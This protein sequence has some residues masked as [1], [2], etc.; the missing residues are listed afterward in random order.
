V[1]V[2]PV[3]SEVLAGGPAP[4]PLAQE[5]AN[6]VT[7]WM[8]NGSSRLGNDATGKIEEPGAT[9]MDAIWTPIAQAVLSPVLGELTNEFASL[10]GPESTP[11]FQSGWYGY[12][13]KDL[14]SELGQPVKGAFSRRY[15]GNG[16]LAACRA[17]LWAAIQTAAEKLAAAQGPEPAAWRESAKRIG[18]LP[19]LIQYTMRWTNRS[20]FQQV[21]EFD[22]HAPEECT[23][24]W[25]N[26]AGGSWFTPGNWSKGAPP[27]PED[28]ACIT[29]NGTYTVTMTQTGATG[30][31]EVNSLTL[32]GA[33]GTQTL[34]VGSSC[35]QSAALTAIAAI[36]NGAHGAL[37]LTNGD[38]CE[39]GVTLEG[40]LAN[41]GKLE[42][43]NLHGGLRSIQG[44]LTNKGTVSLAAGETLHVGGSYT[45]TSAG[46][47]RTFIAGASSFGALSVAG[48][49]TLA[50]TLVSR[51][52]P[53]FKGSPGQTLAIVAGA[54]LSGTF[55][56]ETE[57]QIDYTGLYYK[58]AY[59][60]TAVNLIA[61]QLAVSLSVK[62]GPPG[63]AVTVSGSGYLPG[64]TVTPTFTDHAG[65]K[66]VFP[67]VTTDAGG[68]FSTEIAIG[69]SAAAGAGTI[70]VTSGQTGVHVSRGFTV[71]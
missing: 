14:R 13:Y 2:W 15:C 42:V 33:S 36:T 58:P 23:D 40:P 38:A 18:F 27:G 30:T 4:T 7:A 48:S 50:G 71:T 67:S 70:A 65:V 43:E 22:G 34:A 28:N 19:G 64:D 44:N 52:T 9:I 49:A 5:A 17:S 53:P 61:T 45:Q 55:A 41:A 29:A 60:A 37:A 51:Q 47:L 21:I 39:N 16:S 54:S 24:S 56:S 62:S 10:D 32:G 59:S 25:T 11:E 3:I 57:D 1:K 68:K 69:A 63:S 66:T 8:K 35:S 46:R 12:V 6:L 20:T 31:V 26:T